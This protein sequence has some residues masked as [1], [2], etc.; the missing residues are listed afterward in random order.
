MNLG[1]VTGVS[2]TD[3]TA[4]YLQGW[5]KT[6]L[7]AYGPA[8]RDIM[9]HGHVI[10][11]PW[12]RWLSG[13][14][15]SY[16]INGKNL[17]PNTINKCSA[18]LGLLFGSC[19][20][21]SPAVGPLVNKI[22]VGVLKQVAVPKRAPRPLWTAENMLVFVNAL[23][24]PERNFLDW[25]IMVLQLLCYISMRSFND[26]KNIKVEDVCV[27]ANGDVRF[28]QRVGKTFQNGQGAYVHVKHKRFG[29]FTVKSLL[30]RYVLK[31][32]LK[33]AD[34]LFPQF[35]KSR[36]GVL[37]ICKVPLG[38]GN[39]REELHCVLFELNLPQV[40][41]HSAWASAATMA[42][43]AGLE[44]ST[45]QQGGGWRSSLVLTYIR[46][47]RPLQSVQEVLYNGLNACSSGSSGST[48]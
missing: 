47:E 18:V 4:V 28:F 5:S 45:L 44:V 35:A 37:S 1:C 36:A 42:V 16:L 19:D 48:G 17:A 10:G 8:Y 3:L 23:A 7:H 22:K 11:K 39:A 21:S 29:G 12:Y 27:L 43:E 34:F 6:T 32:G 25:R 15:S 38:Y 31:L 13:D 30:D 20:R 46:S 41:L 24:V 14:V 26:L 33:S 9:R 2:H 40:S